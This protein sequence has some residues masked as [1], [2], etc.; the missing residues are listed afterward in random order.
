MEQD[1]FSTMIFTSRAAASVSNHDL[2]DHREFGLT[3][4]SRL[5]ILPSSPPPLPPPPPPHT[6]LLLL[7]SHPLS[8]PP[9]TPTPHR[10]PQ[11]QSPPPHPL[12]RV[13]IRATLSKGEMREGLRGG[14]MGSGGKEEREEEGE[15]EEEE[16]TLVAYVH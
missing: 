10:R 5:A 12:P 4:D 16:G 6:L 3:L 9:S 1:G 11:H 8:P 14:V 13:I 7:Y 15:K 2:S